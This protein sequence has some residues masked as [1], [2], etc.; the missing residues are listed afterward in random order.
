[1]L[2]ILVLH[3]N[4]VVA[5]GRLVDLL[6]GDTPPKSAAKA[7]QVHIFQLRQLL[8]GGVIVTKPPGY[9]IQ[10]GAGQLDLERF[11]G[12]VAEASALGAEAALPRLREALSLWR[13]P[14]LAE[15]AQERFALGETLRLEELHLDALEKRIEAEIAL[16][17][18][19]GLV[20]ELEA[21]VADHPLRE[22]LRAQLMMALYRSGRQAEAL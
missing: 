9:A 12:L 22:V 18:H 3:A 17:R 19:P 21:L 13:G 5:S 8:G 7:L 6:W 20:G 11:Q 15:F 10:I 14:P 16:E 2:T 4:E 1:L